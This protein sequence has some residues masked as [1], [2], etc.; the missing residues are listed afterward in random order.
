[1]FPLES[2][3]EVGLCLDIRFVG[4]FGLGFLLKR[5]L[6]GEFVFGGLSGLGGGRGALVHVSKL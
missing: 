2:F 1:M 6:G 5:E 4:V 3:F